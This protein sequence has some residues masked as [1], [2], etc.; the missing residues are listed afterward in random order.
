MLE[1]GESKF[2]EEQFLKDYDLA[3]I[4]GVSEDVQEKQKEEKHINISIGNSGDAPNPANYNKSK[5]CYTPNTEEELEN[6][7]IKNEI[8]Y[9]TEIFKILRNHI[10]SGIFIFSIDKYHLAENYQIVG[11]LK[12]VLDK[13]IENFLILLNKMDISTNIE[14]DISSLNGRFLQEFPNGGFNISRNTIIQC[15]AF[16]LENELNM[17]KN[18]SNLLYYHYINYIMNSKKYKYFIESFKEFIKNF[19]KKNIEVD[20]ET[21]ENNINSIVEDEDIKNIKEL[22]IKINKSHDVIR[23][24]LLLSENDF[25]KDSIGNILEDLEEDDDGNINLINQANNILILYYYYLFK[26]KKFTLF[27]ST[28]TQK[29]LNYFTIKNMNR[30]FG[31]KEVQEKLNELQKKETYDK[32]VDDLIKIIKDFEEKYEKVGI[33]LNLKES[34]IISIKPIINIFKTSKMFFIPLIGVYNSGK[35]TILNDIIGCNL[36]PTKQGECT[37]RG[38]LIKHWDYDV[39]ILRKAKFIVENNQSNNDI[40]YFQINYDIITQGEENVKNIL[41]GLNCNFIEKEEDFFYV[42]NVKIEY[43]DTFINND[44]I[45][46]KICFI[47]LPGYG[48]KNKFEEKNIYSKFI[49]SCKLFLMVTRDFFNEKS[50]IEK[51][52]NIISITSRYQNISIQSL[53]KKFLFIINP[54]K[55]LDL[56]ENNL[57][58]QKNSLCNKING[59]NENAI[60]DLNVTFFNALFYKYYLSKKKYF[61]SINFSLKKEEKYYKKDKESFQEGKKS[62]DPG[63]FERYFLKILKDNLKSTFDK[64]LKDIETNEIIDKETNEAVDKLFEVKE[65]SFSEKDLKNIK[66]IFSYAKKNIEKCKYIDESNYTNFRFYLFARI[67]TSKYDADIEF[68][69]TIENNL[70]NLKKIFHNDN[71]LKSGE[72]PVYIEIKNDA[73]TKLK[74]FKKE[75]EEKIKDIK[76][77]IYDK[78]YPKIFEECIGQI[79]NSLINL[80]N[81]IEQDLK[82]EKWEK[83]L[84]KFKENF[85]NETNNQKEIIVSNLEDLSNNLKKNYNEAFKIINKFKNNPGNIYQMDELKIYISNQLGERNDYKEAISNIVNYIL[86]DSKNAT[87]WENRDGIFDYFKNKIFNK[88]YLNKTFDFITKSAS[89]KLNEFKIILSRHIE[90]YMKQ[91]LNKINIEEISLINNLEE[92]KR[93]K[94]NENERNKKLNDKEKKKYEEKIKEEEELKKNWNIL[95][96]EYDKLEKLIKNILEGN[97]N[98]D[99]ENENKENKDNKENE[100]KE[101][102]HKENSFYEDIGLTSQ[103]EFNSI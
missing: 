10:K 101:K 54:S 77:A 45:K 23:Y 79:T 7:N 71:N 93:M 55:N 41:K 28:Q 44:E 89:K 57:L 12:L 81:T 84:N 43:L 24:K 87:N 1:I 63:K 69:K 59:L 78:E 52:N 22:I 11:K 80:T 92:Q 29:I 15:S 9:L 47:D 83:V 5:L 36:L 33:N 75:I 14:E 76:V 21:F 74:E 16:Q 67:T 68:K 42:I 19:L 30:D 49:K 2:I 31:Y 85:K 91:I 40:C 37:K 50:V 64:T 4:P 98:G 66:L 35:S 26:N 38:I 60:R 73:D 39:P 8:S 95:C 17:D 97:K 72:P 13:P 32:K 61:N 88:D 86:L 27:K 46:E 65:Y 102:E 94:D 62:I 70:D 51:I 58:K 48:T 99:K 25:N 96:Q 18:F 53:I 34:F 56:S 82:T 90:E 3:D 100:E 103:I 6:F 20:K